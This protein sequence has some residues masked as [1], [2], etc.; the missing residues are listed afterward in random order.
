MQ[1]TVF[2]FLKISRFCVFTQPASHSLPPQTV[3]RRVKSISAV[4]S[5][6]SRCVVL[7]VCVYECECVMPRSFINSFISRPAPSSPT[8]CCLFSFFP[9]FHT[10][11]HTC[12]FFLFNTHTH[13][14]AHSPPV[15]KCTHSRGHLNTLKITELLHKRLCKQMSGIQPFAQVYKERHWLLIPRLTYCS[16]NNSTQQGS[17]IGLLFPDSEVD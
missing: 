1:S 17:P 3:F 11:G 2:F 14:L 7:C 10:Q 12:S 13:F 5:V 16:A 6:M 15:N 9:Y 8:S 4:I